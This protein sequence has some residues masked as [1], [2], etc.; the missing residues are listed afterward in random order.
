MKQKLLITILLLLV[1]LT[2]LAACAEEGIRFEQTAV[3]VFE[4]EQA[5]LT[6]TVSDGLRDG[7]VTYKSGDP[8]VATVDA[9]GQVT[10]VARG[11]A[12]ITATLKTAKQS[13]KA[14]V[15]VTVLRAVTSVELSKEGLSILTV[16]DGLTFSL[17]QNLLS[18]GLPETEYEAGMALEQ[19]IL[20]SVGRKATFQPILKPNSASDKSFTITSSDETVLS[21]RKQSVTAQQPGASIVTVASVSNPDILA[22]YG[23]LVVTPASKLTVDTVRSTIGVG[24]TTQLDAT[25]SPEN[26]T[27]RA[28]K[29]T[30]EN[31]KVASVD[32]NGLVTGLMKG[33]TT[34]RANALDGSGKRD[35][36]VIYVQQLPTGI[37]ITGETDIQLATGQSHAFKATLTPS[38]VSN[39][40]VTW[41]SSDPAVA[42]VSQ[43]GRVTAVALGSCEIIA[44]SAA[45]PDLTATVH[46]TVIQQVTSIKFTQRSMDLNVGSAALVEAQVNPADATN[47]AIA[48]SVDNTKIATIDE[49]GMVQA[50]SRG[51]TTIR[52]KSKDG[53][54]RTAS[55][56]LNVIQLPES[57]TVD[58]PN[59]TV[60][61]GRSATVRATVLPKNANKTRVNWESTD[62][63]I[64]KVNNDGQSTGVKAGT[65]QVIC[66]TRADA[67]VTAIVD[68]TVHQLVTKITPEQRNLTVNVQEST[69]IRWTVGPDDVT[70]PSVTLT[71]N[72]PAI[73]TVDQNGV[74][75][76]LKRGE[77]TVTIKADDGSNKQATVR[78]NVLQPV[79]GVQMKDAH[80]QTDVD[81]QVRLTAQLIPSDASNTNM[82]WHSADESIA[83]VK[84]KSTRPTVTG[85]RWGT[86]EITGYTEDGGYSAS[87]LVTV[88]NYDTA[89]RATDLYLSDNA[90]KLSLINVSN[91][92]ISRV[93]F[94]VECFDI[95]N[96]PL[97]CN[98]NG[99]NVFDGLY[100]YPLG[101]R[102]STRHGRFNFI[103]YVQPSAEIG[104]VV[105]TITSYRYGMANEWQS[106]AYDIPENRQTSLE[107]TSPNYIGYLPLQ[108][109]EPP[110]DYTVTEEEDFIDPV[111]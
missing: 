29:W 37:S 10:G 102:E 8:R 81:G 26:T 28:V 6:L 51:S 107:Y 23:V 94:T 49:N 59:V 15:K 16:D 109:D 56:T 66:R 80:Y 47:P 90:V 36:V 85:H 11:S 64:A 22:K 58:K 45:D 89:I 61:T 67:S 41:S 3:S 74:V 69:Q 65:C 60:N 1:C 83:T 44:A 54:N 63:S 98:V 7:S 111:G 57:V 52:A 32:E 70:D 17:A 43:E 4:N 27:F 108:E 68:V 46:I 73:A 12:V 88:Q 82:V 78:I 2:G 100:Q 96:V 79:E 93:E 75:Y 19:I 50:I 95:Y 48:Y 40:S 71:S 25:F 14:T 106:W 31:P 76:G 110:E 13:Y 34:I 5:Q 21:V 9:N 55:M 42:R 91:L 99:S 20:L 39:K 92:D 104:R 87:T 86:V 53:S 84:G 30:S 24:G 103:D 72:K 97:A 35:S 105:L 33:Q 38:N 101:E 18:D 77:C 62:T